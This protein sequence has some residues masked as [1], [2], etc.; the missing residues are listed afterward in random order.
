[1][2]YST[3]ALNNLI[4]VTGPDRGWKP[5]LG[6]EAKLSDCRSC[7]SGRRSA[8][9]VKASSQPFSKEPAGASVKDRDPQ[10]PPLTTPSGWF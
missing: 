5:D 3:K 6:L 4:E 1:M 2:N 9:L 10:P 8:P 7:A